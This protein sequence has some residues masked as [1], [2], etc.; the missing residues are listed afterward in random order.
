MTTGDFTTTYT[1]GDGQCMDSA[2]LT[3]TI[4]ETIDAD[5]EEVDD[6]TLCENAGVQ[7]LTD[8]LGDNP[9]IGTFEGYEDG[10]FNPGAQGP[11]SYEITYSLNGDNDD[12]QCVNGSDSISFTI[13]VT[14]SAFA[15]MDTTARLCESDAVLDLSTLLSDNAD[16][17]GTFTV[18]GE[19]VDEGMFDPSQFEVGTVEVIYTVAAINDCGNDTATITV[20]VDEAPDAGEDL[21]LTV[22]QNAEDQNLFDL[23]DDDTDTDGTFT[24]DGN[25]LENGLLNPSD[26]DPSTFDVTYTLSNET[27]DDTA[28]ISI[29]IRDAANAGEDMDIAYCMSDDVQN[30]FDFISA[31]ADTNG[32]FSLNGETVEDG[33]L[34]PS[35][36]EAGTLEV[37]YTVS[38]IN[39]CGDDT[40]TFT[41][42]ILEAPAA[43]TVTD[44]TFCASDMPT[45]ANLVE[46]PTGFT[47]YTDEAL[48]MMAALEDAVVEGVYYVTQTATDNG[49]E[50]QAA[51]I[52]VS[53]SDLPTPTV[54]F[55][56]DVL[57]RFS[58]PDVGDI[59]EAVDEDGD[60]AVYD[61]EDSNDA[62]SPGTPL[63]DGVTYYVALRN[64]DTGCESSVRL[65]IT[66]TLED[67]PLV[68][69]EGISPNGDGLNDTFVI[70]NIGREYPNYTIKIYNRWGDMVYKGNASTDPWDGYSTEGSLG[71][72]ILPVGA[73]FYIIDF[74]D[75]STPP[76][77]GNVYLSR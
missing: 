77:R 28:T 74:N 37:I 50:S 26:F 15:G 9:T 4:R 65:P 70:E 16:T 54:N 69:P 34:D 5:L 22:C 21:T 36:F 76:K 6:V 51:I 44:V 73:Y 7:N 46:D 29:T 72:E 17:N 41:I 57:C 14:E 24:V 49:C 12:T 75:G 61:T 8:F 25:T 1:I 63:Q 71:D 3:L 27:C 35:T 55:G 47:F 43:P 52:N 53:L 2:E 45:V 62:L 10:T 68:F 11:G 32:T 58:D 19:T 13:T 59:I 18:N 33:M 31:D 39:D 64:N 42:S 48:T 38:A 30:L 60:V 40:A 20:T 67:C 56:P 23:L 66:I